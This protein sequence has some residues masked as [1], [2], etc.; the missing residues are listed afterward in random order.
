MAPLAQH[1]LQ[2]HDGLSEAVVT[3]SAAESRSPLSQ[4]SPG[5]PRHDRA[6]GVRGDATGEV[7]QI[8]A[9]APAV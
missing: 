2:C 7:N 4:P 1:R 9:H 3:S 5:R 6:Q 8:L